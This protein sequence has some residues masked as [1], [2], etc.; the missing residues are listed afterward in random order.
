MG[1]AGERVKARRC[2]RQA[3][4]RPLNAR[5]HSPHAKI[6]GISSTADA[7]VAPGHRGFNQVSVKVQPRGGMGVSYGGALGLRTC[8]ATL[9]GQA[10][11][12]VSEP[13]G[14][15]RKMRTV[16]AAAGNAQVQMDLALRLAFGTPS[17][18]PVV[19]PYACQ[20]ACAARW[21]RTARFGGLLLLMA[22]AGLADGC[23]VH[24]KGEHGPACTTIDSATRIVVYSTQRLTILKRVAKQKDLSQH[25]QT[26]LVNAI[27]MGGFGEDMAD[28]AVNLIDNPCCTAETR[29]HIRERLKWTH[30]LGR[31]E[32]RILDELKRHEPREA[33]S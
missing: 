9:K 18:S 8:V 3:P 30:M 1:W 19:A 16:G 29:A 17:A 6:A 31:P 12:G 5:G 7:A 25:E 21:R 10:M 11:D 2:S 32:R 24:P 23:A 15:R 4:H 22:A 14:E 20:R 28:A 26:Y 13:V 33:E 27:F